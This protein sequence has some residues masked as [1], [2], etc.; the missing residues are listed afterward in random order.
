MAT[1]LAGPP[2]GVVAPGPVA[3]DSDAHKRLFC[4]LMPDTH[5]P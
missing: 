2:I 3:I 5:D 1:S 4:G